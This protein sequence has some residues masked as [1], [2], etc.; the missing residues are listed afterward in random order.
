MSI[1]EHIPLGQ[2][3]QSR[4]SQYAKKASCQIEPRLSYESSDRNPLKRGVKGFSGYAWCYDSFIGE[5]VLRYIVVAYC[6]VPR[7][8]RFPCGM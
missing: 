6:T 5:E 3:L 2:G 8:P 1:N 4:K 7:A